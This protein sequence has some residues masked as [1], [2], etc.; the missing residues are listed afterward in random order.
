MAQK[1]I[2]SVVTTSVLH[3]NTTENIFS[4]VSFDLYQMRIKYESCE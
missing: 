3:S 4:Y 1:K 2:Q